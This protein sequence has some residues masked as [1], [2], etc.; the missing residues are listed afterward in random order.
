MNRLEMF[1]AVE[2]GKV[3][4]ESCVYR[5]LIDQAKYR[6]FQ[7]FTLSDFP[8]TCFVIN[9]AE[10]DKMLTADLSFREFPALLK[11]VVEYEK[12][13][14]VE[15]N[16]VKYRIGD[17]QVTFVTIST[18]Q[19]PAIKGLLLEISFLPVCFPSNCGELLFAF[20]RQHFPEL[21]VGSPN[22]NIFTPTLK[23][24][25]MDNVTPDIL[26]KSTP[27]KLLMGES[28]TALSRASARITVAQYIER[29]REIRTH[30]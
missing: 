8:A 30:Q 26:S 23:K 24:A 28:L 6:S 10:P 21:F 20:G 7:I 25:F 17:F 2:V 14:Q 5:S 3:R 1:G 11:G 16:G 18:G 9:D 27:E 4:L 29:I 12:K 22:S 19:S 15:G 13:L